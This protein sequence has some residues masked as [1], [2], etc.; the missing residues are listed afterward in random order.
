MGPVLYILALLYVYFSPSAVYFSPI[1]EC[2]NP[3]VLSLLLPHQSHSMPFLPIKLAVG[4]LKTTA[5]VNYILMPGTMDS[6]IT[7]KTE[8]VSSGFPTTVTPS[9]N[10]PGT[11]SSW[12]GREWFLR[13][14]A[15][16][17][18][19]RPRQQLQSG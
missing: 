11:A 2:C 8:I 3:E 15:N 12:K 7:E 1:A 4:V 6:G 16:P 18:K 14:K 9:S 10:Q 13:S 5:G 19:H 17:A